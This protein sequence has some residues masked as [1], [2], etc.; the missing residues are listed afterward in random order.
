MT[1]RT[2]LLDDREHWRMLVDG[3]AAAD[4]QIEM[5]ARAAAAGEVLQLIHDARP[6]VVLLDDYVPWT[7]EHPVGQYAV[8]LAMEISCRFDEAERPRL[9][10]WSH[11]IDSRDA[12][13]FCFYG[14]ALVCEKDADDP[15]AAALAAIRKAA[16]GDRDSFPSPRPARP[17]LH[18]EIMRD[19]IVLSGLEEGMDNGQIAAV[20]ASLRSTSLGDTARARQRIAHILSR[21]REALDVADRG[22]RHELVTAAREAGYRWVRVEHAL[23][24]KELQRRY[25]DRRLPVFVSPARTA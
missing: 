17:D 21:F 20:R 22:A 23:L 14:G 24:A 7:P 11:R 8:R 1:I 12:Y 16:A 2:V 19:L 13:A 15:A 9:V 5:V 6:D 25:P 10:M 4:D 18:G 3:G